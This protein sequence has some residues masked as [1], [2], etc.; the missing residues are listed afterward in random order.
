MCPSLRLRAPNYIAYRFLPC[1]GWGR[2]TS[3]DLSW[4]C[5][6]IILCWRTLTPHIFDFDFHP[7]CRIQFFSQFISCAISGHRPVPPYP[8]TPNTHPV[9]QMAPNHSPALLRIQ[10]L[11]HQHAIETFASFFTPNYRT[12][13]LHLLPNETN[14]NDEEPVEP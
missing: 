1:S 4:S 8:H 3:F 10:C 14:A 9:D 12:Y 2:Y 7:L 5:S 11:E 6:W 13:C